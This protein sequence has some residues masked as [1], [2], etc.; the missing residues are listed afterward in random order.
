M[1]RSN[2]RYAFT[3]WHDWRILGNNEVIDELQSEMLGL[4][5]EKCRM[6]CHNLGT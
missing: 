2:V 3:M 4:M 1:T 5:I 6:R